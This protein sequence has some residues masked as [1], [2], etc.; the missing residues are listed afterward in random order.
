MHEIA[1]DF[2]HEMLVPGLRLPDDDA[3][4]I[5]PS[6]PPG[7]LNPSI[8]RCCQTNQRYEA[9]RSGESIL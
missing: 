5:S 6:G 2:T 9:H 7:S 8:P 4:R 1:D 3:R